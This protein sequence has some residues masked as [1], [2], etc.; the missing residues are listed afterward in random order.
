MGRA[1][2]YSQSDAPD[3]VLDPALVTEIAA[4]HTD[5]AG[6][7]LEVDESGG[8]A[9]AYLFQGDLVVKTQRPHRLRP[10]TSLS[11]EATLLAHLSS[12][13][14]ARIP[15]VYGYG[16]RQTAQGEV[17]YIVM[18]RIPG[19]AAKHIRVE[20]ARRVELLRQAGRTIAAIHT[21]P[22]APSL[23]DDGLLPADTDG[24]ALRRRLEF[25]FAD[26]GDA[27]AERPDRWS[28]AVS[29]EEA[30]N[31]ALSLIPEQFTAVALH[32]NPGPTHVFCDADG[33][34][35]GVIDFGD[36]Y[37]SHPAMDLR[38]W[39]DPADRIALREGY[40]EVRDPDSAFDAAWTAAMIYMD[41]A[42]IVSRPQLAA[43]ATADLARRVA[44]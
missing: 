26:I 19:R 16:S 38:V 33:A 40:L 8:E 6:A 25:G 18:S 21:V 31:H 28:A 15:H 30:A 36:A 13:L 5:H 9:R 22:I 4:A 29:L 24:A 32:S 27:L 44:A 34:L 20:G 7:M 39:P 14:G 10:R 12:A 43:H 11:K 17:E 37:A 3:P 35:T 42:V 23:L 2:T 1:D 41:A